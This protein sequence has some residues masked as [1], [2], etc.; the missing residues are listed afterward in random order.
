MELSQCTISPCFLF[1]LVR[2]APLA[3]L[4]EPQ[5]G[6]GTRKFPWMQQ[7]TCL[8]FMCKDVQRWT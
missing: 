2:S 8:I 3:Q 1:H 5:D 6:E 7:L 4:S